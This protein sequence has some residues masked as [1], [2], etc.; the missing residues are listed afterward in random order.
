MNTSKIRILLICPPPLSII[1]P[2]Q[3]APMWGRTA[4][5]YLA[6]Y[7]RKTGD[8]SIKIIDAKLE[9][10]GFPEVL[11]QALA[12][13]PHIV[14]FTAF[15]NEIKPAAY[16]SAL[17]KSH[18]PS[19]HTVIGG[20]HV[21]TL[22]K[23]TLIEFKDFD[24]AVVGEGEITFSEL[25]DAIANNKPLA[26]IKGI[27]FRKNGDIIQTSDRERIIDQDSIPLP[28]WDLMPSA[29]TYYIQT[30]RGCPFS[31]HFCV[32]HNGKVAR[33]RS[34]DNVISEFELLIRE[35]NPRSI[36]FGDELFTIDNQRTHLLLD[37]MIE[38]KIGQ[39]IKW[40]N[41]THVR[42][43]NYD[44]F[45]KMKKAN[46]YQTHMGVETG[47][48]AALSKLGKG[49]T[50]EMIT[51]A[52]ADAK[53]AEITMGAFFIFGQPNETLESIKKTIDLAVKINVHLPMFGLMVPYPGTELSR[54]ASKGEGGYSGLS[55][56]WDDY[57]NRIGGAVNLTA[58]TRKQLDFILMKAY[59]KVFLYN[60]R[61]L[62]FI[63]FAWDY[64][65]AAMNLLK[66]I[67]FNKE[68]TSLMMQK[69][70]GY[71]A[72][73][74]KNQKATPQDFIYSKES[75]DIIQKKDIKRIRDISPNLIA[76]Q[77]ML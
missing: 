55:E 63:K 42:F 25:C 69:P 37:K 5:A 18:N 30:E 72:L 74:A 58:F 60:F 26:N 45:K 71:D 12:F 66:K 36:N 70:D 61:I 23:Q 27:V 7:L 33:K 75:F 52:F 17:I 50:V 40:M 24:I 15:T 76:E 65:Q 3:D 19:I 8:Y 2:W 29:D 11:N 31:C 48:E 56:D 47:D 21:T 46:V 64:R 1:E 53:R 6:G 54:L 32:N 73:F 9:R 49:T 77:K 62:D 13:K 43:V 14:G 39:K 44:L 16:L 20:V 22:P 28:A 34:V 57:R 67:I 4:L 68:N 38:K 35:H 59:L 10:L 51:K 41:Q